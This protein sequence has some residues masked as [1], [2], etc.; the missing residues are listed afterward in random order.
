MK[1]RRTTAF[2]AASIAVF[3]TFSCGSSESSTRVKNSALAK[4]PVLVNGSFSKSG[5]GWKMAETSF[6]VSGSCAL[7]GDGNPSLGTHTASQLVFGRKKASVS[8]EIMVPEPGTVTFAVLHEIPRPRGFG[9]IPAKASITLSDSNERYEKTSSGA[10]KIEATVT[11][12]QNNEKITIVITGIPGSS[13]NGCKGAA[14]SDATLIYAK[15]LPP[16]TT[17]TTTAPSIPILINGTF[18]PDGGGWETEG[19]GPVGKGCFDTAASVPMR[20]AASLGYAVNSRLTFGSHPSTVFQRVTVPKPGTI[21]FTLTLAKRTSTQWMQLSLKGSEFSGIDV[22]TEG[23]HSLSLQT[24][25]NNEVVQIRIDPITDRRGPGCHGIQVSDA[26]LSYVE[27]TPVTTPPA[28]TTTVDPNHPPCGGNVAC[29]VGNTGP[30]GGLVY[31]V[32]EQQPS[33]YNR[34][35]EI[36]PPS[37]NGGTSD[38]VLTVDEAYNKVSEGVR[39]GSGA[40]TRS[41]WNSDADVDWRVP[42]ISE[43]EQIYK[44]PNKGGITGGE[45]LSSTRASLQDPTFYFFNF[46]TGQQRIT[47]LANWRN[48]KA[49]VRPIRRGPSPCAFGGACKVGDVGPGGGKVFYVTTKDKPIVTNAAPCNGWNPCLYM[50]VA[51]QTWN[52]GTSDPTK[53]WANTQGCCQMVPN[54]GAVGTGIGAGNLNTESILQQQQSFDSAARAAW[55]G[56]GNIGRWYLPSRD[57]LVELYKNSAKVDGP[58]AN[59][60]WSSTEPNP[61][62]M[63]AYTVDFSTGDVSNMQYKDGMGQPPKY[64]RP[65]RAF[66]PACPCK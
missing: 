40:V 17:S 59:L 33:R 13:S 4:T 45:Y 39:E 10:K 66:A 28:T 11:T 48:E 14:F 41:P 2:L 31:F 9:D 23:T 63:V 65:V 37:W 43:L 8:Q 57:E 55:Y 62:Q 53:L 21:T 5:G 25:S 22:R 24:T 56:N 19:L 26:K 35:F 3:T 30:G 61:G 29:K 1:L 12:T 52:G 58:T 16:T 38:P 50:E 47:S 44:S 46:T 36:A 27:T 51:P 49:L 18:Q 42:K 15:T 60:Y 34:Y 64:V 20:N 6:P 54:N 7:G 32:D